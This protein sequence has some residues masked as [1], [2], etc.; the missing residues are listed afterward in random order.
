MMK[1]L[2]TLDRKAE[3][4]IEDLDRTVNPLIARGVDQDSYAMVEAQPPRENTHQAS[5][6]AKADCQPA[7]VATGQYTALQN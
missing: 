1:L 4:I 6:P 3:Q 7:K 5:A 2:Q